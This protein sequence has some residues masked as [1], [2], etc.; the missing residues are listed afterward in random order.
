MRVTKAVELTQAERG[1]MRVRCKAEGHA[2]E[3]VRHFVYPFYQ[4]CQVCKWC[5]ERR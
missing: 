4:F 3:D 2:W 5:G 1:V